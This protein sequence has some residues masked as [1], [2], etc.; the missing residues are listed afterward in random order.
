MKIQQTETRLRP[1][2]VELRR[3]KVAAITSGDVLPKMV[4]PTVCS[5]YIS[6]VNYKI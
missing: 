5:Y 2:V 4:K 3:G 6:I 1:R